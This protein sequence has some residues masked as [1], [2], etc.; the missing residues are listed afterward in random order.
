MMLAM[1]I[2]EG[3]KA[4]LAKLDPERQEAVRKAA[5][6]MKDGTWAEWEAKSKMPITNSSGSATAP[7]MQMLLAAENA[8]EAR[9]ARAIVL[10]AAEKDRKDE[11]RR[12]GHKKD[13]ARRR[14]LRAKQRRKR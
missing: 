4:E 9:K 6:I 3:L 2:P 11:K 7:G 10:R 14:R 8:E 12:Q 13:R 5:E 1:E